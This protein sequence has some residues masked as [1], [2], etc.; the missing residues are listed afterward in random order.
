MSPGSKIFLIGKSRL[1]FST[2]FPDYP[3]LIKN[4]FV[5]LESVNPEHFYQKN[6][7]VCKFNPSRRNANDTKF[8]LPLYYI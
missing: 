5:D 6:V 4:I 3:Y 2:Q 8:F 1:S 7:C